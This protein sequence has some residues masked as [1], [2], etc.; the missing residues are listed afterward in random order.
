MSLK[1]VSKARR[2]TGIMALAV[3]INYAVSLVA[4]EKLSEKSCCEA[5]G[6]RTTLFG[7]FGISVKWP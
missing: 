1:V 4:P 6:K 7:F 5:E 2:S 3:C